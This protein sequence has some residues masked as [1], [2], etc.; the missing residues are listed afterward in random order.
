MKITREAF[1]DLFGA[2]L[3]EWLPSAW[4]NGTR[5]VFVAGTDEIEDLEHLL[6]GGVIS[7]KP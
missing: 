2:C 5:Y 6:L 4:V 3:A 7:G 1:A